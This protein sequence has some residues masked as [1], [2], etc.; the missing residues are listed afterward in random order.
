[1][2]GEGIPEQMLT[3]Y[4]L[5]TA[6]GSQL[7]V[8]GKYIGV[9]RNIGIP[10]VRPYFGFWAS[11]QPDLDPALY[12]G[13]WNPVTDTPALGA[14]SI[15]EWWVVSTTGT[16]TTPIPADWLSG[17]VILRIGV[18][19]FVQYTTNSPNGNGFTA[20]ANPGIN[21]EGIFY[22]TAYISGQNSDLTDAE[23]RTVLKLKIV[24]NSSDGTLA[25]I[26]AYLQEFFPSLI[27][28]VD[29]KDMTLSYAVVSTVALSKELLEI[30]LPRPMG[31]GITVT[32]I[33][34]IPGGGDTLTTEDGDILTTESGD[35]L[36]TETV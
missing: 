35:P 5:D 27:Y 17:N 13:T 33:S 21:A 19:T 34:P 30:Y 32:I 20:S 26:M 25:S 29:N 4:D 12:Q 7:D 14:G 28:L 15:G 16:S 2:T 23:Y 3:A 24:L 11:A 1:M 31:V 36:V 6:V 18:S 8:L 9:S 10:Q 22:S